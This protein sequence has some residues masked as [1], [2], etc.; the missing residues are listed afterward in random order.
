MAFSKEVAILRR[1]RHPKLVEFLGATKRDPKA[2][3]DVLKF[4]IVLELMEGGALD[5]LL[6]AGTPA[7]G[8]ASAEALLWYRP[9]STS[10]E[11]QS[12]S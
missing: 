12:K 2:G 4:R 10:R 7:N 9:L 8:G 1:L 6:Y 5:T 3:R 11:S